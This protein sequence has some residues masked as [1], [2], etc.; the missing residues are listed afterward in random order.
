M[1]RL[2]ASIL[3]EAGFKVLAKTTGSKPIIIFPDGREEEIKRRDI[4]SILEQKKLLKLGAE[5]KINAL[6]SELM[7]IQPESGYV[8]SVQILRPH[9]LV[10]TNVRLDHLAQ[11]GFSKEAIARCFASSIP[12]ISTVF[13]PQEEFFP[14]FQKT[15][16]KLESKVIQ[17]PG[18]IFEDNLQPKKKSPFFKLKENVHL[19]LAV[20]E[21][22][23][24]NR[25]VA[26]QGREK[27]QPDFG[28]LK[29]WAAEL[30]L[31]SRHFNF[32]SGFAANDPES[33]RLVL[34]KLW[35]NKNFEG[36]KLIGLLNFR[37]DRGDR[38][39]QW[40]KALKENAFPEFSRFY[41]AGVHAHAFK[42]KLKFSDKI[43][44]T[45]LKK[46]TPEKI[47]EQVLKEEKE[48]AVLVGMGN[49]GGIGKRLVYYWEKIGRPYDL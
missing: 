44:V 8:E 45:V 20:A 36:K 15:A 9:F 21:F 18:D 35:K 26:L 22:L 5:L 27:V 11:M 28:S 48:E 37:K 7:S 10:I 41:L 32:V 25:E 24:I 6:V 12:E 17:V 46:R 3:R 2:I 14:V 16:E 43:S 47:I 40:L 19:A 31:P 30:G 4:S 34:S 13:I 33:T 23:G 39:L 49:M 29:V 38:T 1:T 42:R